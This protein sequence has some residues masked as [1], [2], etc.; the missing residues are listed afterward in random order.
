[1][2]LEKEKQSKP[3]G[4]KKKKHNIQREEIN[5]IENSKQSGKINETKS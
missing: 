1:M 2:N 3:K 4:R 5:E